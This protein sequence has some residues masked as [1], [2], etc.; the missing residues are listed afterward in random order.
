MTKEYLLLDSSGKVIDRL[1]LT[2]KEVKEL[3]NSGYRVLPV[4]IGR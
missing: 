2:T 4:G 3:R 1:N